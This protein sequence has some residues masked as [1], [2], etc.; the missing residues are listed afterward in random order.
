MSQTINLPTTITNKAVVAIGTPGAG[1]SHGVAE[2]IVIPAL[3]RHEQVVIVDP[4][5]AWFGL[6][7]SKDGKRP[8]GLDIAVIGGE[9][10][11]IPLTPNMGTAMGDLLGREPIS[12]I[13]SLSHLELDEQI[14]F[15]SDFS[16]A[17]MR[18]N[19]KPIRL[20]YDEADEFCP[21]K[22]ELGKELFKCRLSVRRIVT[23]GRK[24]GFRPVLITQR[25]QALS[26]AARNLCQVMMAFQCAGHHERKQIKDYVENNGDP[27]T[28]KDMLGTLGQLAV[29]EAWVWAPRVRF[30]QRVQF[31][32][33]EVYD[34]FKDLDESTANIA[35]VPISQKHLASL[36]KSLEEFEQQRKA[37]DPKELRERVAEL[38][39]LLS[40][41]EQHDPMTAGAGP[42]E[43]EAEYQRGRAAERL[44]LLEWLEQH[45]GALRNAMFAAEEGIQSIRAALDESPPL[46][47]AGTIPEEAW[48]G[49]RMVKPRA[50]KPEPRTQSPPRQSRRVAGETHPEPGELNGSQRR[51][52]NALAWW[53]V[54]GKHEPTV[55]MIA[56]VAGWKPSSG[57]TNNR[58]SEL[59]TMGLVERRSPGTAS[60]TPAGQAAAK[61]GDAPRNVLQVHDKVRNVLT[62]SQ[63]KV[64]EALR[65]SY[66]KSMTVVD[67]ARACG[68]TDESGGT[69][70]R[71]SELVTMSIAERPKPGEVKLQQWLVR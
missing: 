5:D 17:I 61:P 63:V 24:P 56:V 7:L 31:S 49:A 71:V 14:Q 55:P 16:R 48:T 1:K 29:G 57:G 35:A 23:R 51:A 42:E 26:V 6:A 44:A 3:Q 62:G 60:L 37:N 39:Y 15:V 34:S 32:K 28:M 18:V 36:K 11:Q 2:S 43:L 13:L 59:C 47:D 52:L 70:N 40:Q 45:N 4:T 8:S 9:H 10:G 54:L 50:T 38:E 21:E 65:A 53:Q 19:R 66:P 20:I 27:A 58:L 33:I 46:K 12:A 30:L 68:W 22:P 69:N 41:T 64:F 25:P 67:I